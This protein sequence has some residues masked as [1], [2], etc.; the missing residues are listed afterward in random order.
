MDGHQA[1]KLEAILA[2]L[3]RA[4]TSVEEAGD[5]AMVIGWLSDDIRIVTKTMIRLGLEP[6][7]VKTLEL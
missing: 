6:D 4:L 1:A 7:A 5:K 3:K 2:T